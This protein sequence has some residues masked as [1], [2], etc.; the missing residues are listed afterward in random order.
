MGS[1]TFDLRH[2]VR[3]LITTPVFSVVTILT[4]ALGIG[5]NSAIFSLVNAALLRPVGYVEPE[6]IM[7]IHESIPESKLP[8]FGVS[9]P[10]YLDL[11]RY[12]GSFNALG[13]YRTVSAE[14]SGAGQPETIVVAQ[15]SSAV[16]QVLG[17]RPAETRR[18]GSAH[19]PTAASP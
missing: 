13:I 4:L 14:L 19:A 2:G 7:M 17:V 11:D 16:L 1:L 9:P 6:R 8:R 15:T 3:A 18:P 5:A 12:Q 10:D